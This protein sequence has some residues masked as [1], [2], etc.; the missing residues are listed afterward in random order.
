MDHSKM[1]IIIYERAVFSFSFLL[2]N[3]YR[4]ITELL[5]ENGNLVHSRPTRD[6]NVLNFLHNSAGEPRHKRRR[7]ESSLA[8][9]VHLAMT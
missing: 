5:I 7:H 9:Y 4:A 3:G 6:Q 1:F 8:N 2:V